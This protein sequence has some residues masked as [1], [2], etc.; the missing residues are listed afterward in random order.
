MFATECFGDHNICV[1][2]RASGG[3]DAAAGNGLPGSVA[4]VKAL[5]VVDA[6]Y[7]LC[8]KD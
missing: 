4:V 6:F 7:I 1:V 8:L 5:V 2:R 3:R